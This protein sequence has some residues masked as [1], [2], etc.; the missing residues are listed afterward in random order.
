MILMEEGVFKYTYLRRKKTH[1]NG[2]DIIINFVS[3]EIRRV[4]PE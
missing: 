4:A 3:L 2:H 1:T